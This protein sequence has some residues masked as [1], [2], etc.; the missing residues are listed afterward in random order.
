[1][2]YPVEPYVLPANQPLTVSFSPSTDN[3]SLSKFQ[4]GNQPPVQQGKVT[5]RQATSSQPIPSTARVTLTPESTGQHYTLKWSSTH[6]FDV[7]YGQYTVAAS[8][9][10]GDKTESIQVS[11]ATIELT[12][13]HPGTTLNLNYQ[14]H[15]GHITFKL[16]HTQPSGTSKNITVDVTDAADHSTHP[17]TIPWGKTAEFTHLIPKHQ[18]QFSA[19]DVMGD[20]Q[21]YQFSFSPQTITATPNQQTYA[22]TI[23]AQGHA[24]T[25]YDTFVSVSG[26]PKGI[27]T[28]LHFVPKDST[29]KTYTFTQVGNGT[30]AQ[31]YELPSGSYQLSA[32]TVT[33]A[34]QQYSTTAQPVTIKPGDNRINILFH[35]KPIPV[36]D[37]PLMP[38]KDMTF[39]MNWSANPPRSNPLEMVKASGQKDYTLAFVTQDALASSCSPA[40]GGS[41]SLA[42]SK[43]LY[44][45]DINTLRQEGGHIAISF[46]GENGTTLAAKCT[47]S[48]LEYAYKAVISTYKPSY[49]DFDIEGGA[50]GDTAANAKRFEVLK[51]LQTQ[52]TS[53]KI[54][55]TLPANIDGFGHQAVTLIQQ[56]KAMGVNIYEYNM[57]T[58][59]WYAQKDPNVS[60]AKNVE[61][62][63]QKG[64][65]QLKSI[66]P[67]LSDAQIWKT[68]RVTPKLGIDYDGSV[69]KTQ[70]AEIVGSFVKAKDMAGAAFWSMDIDRNNNIN[71]NC[72]ATSADPSCSGV[73][74]YPYEYTHEF[75][76]GLGLK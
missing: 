1:M 54:S 65:E 39:N 26:L 22:V 57:M 18:Y 32:D 76:K 21:S 23:T 49:I 53:L 33:H 58:M 55:L 17:M 67:D 19:Q 61:I 8:I 2:W 20:Q 31:A 10:N 59:A 60:I 25:T 15:Q 75:R 41:P 62:S 16:P 36:M 51:A 14:K 5:L 11:P 73:D 6:Q 69:F 3:F 52:D 56:A 48:Q 46:C 70:G 34:Q 37:F 24:V 45:N 12:A 29:G 47:Q 42:V 71:G 40:W 66:F 35:G 27:K 44:L 28:N 43:K 4:V 13:Q 30:N 38:F 74:Q 72:G 68:I 9:Q 7:N 50:L 63:A 64:F